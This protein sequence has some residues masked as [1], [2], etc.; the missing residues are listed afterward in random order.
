[1]KDKNFVHT[2]KICPYNWTTYLILDHFTMILFFNRP[3][4]LLKVALSTTNLNLKIDRTC[5][6]IFECYI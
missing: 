5:M 3:E 1:M 4:V 6:A 2:L